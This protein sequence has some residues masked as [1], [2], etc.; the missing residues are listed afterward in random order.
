MTTLKRA[1]KWPAYS[2]LAAGALIGFTA[3]AQPSYAADA[4]QSSHVR[5][6]TA[7]AIIYSRHDGRC[8]DED[9]ASVTH[10]GTKAQVW[11]CHG[12]NNQKWTVYSDGTIRVT[13]DGR[14]L[15]EDIAGGTRNGTKVQL[16]NCTGGDNQKWTVYTDGRIVNGHDGRCLDEDIAG[17]TRNGTKVQ[18]WQC[19]GGDNQGWVHL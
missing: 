12:G 3:A 1:T 16:W 8:L 13:H 4:G 19:T 2:L 15:D 14:C 6:W 9:V 10:N 7:N 11:D 5:P 17:G 18:V